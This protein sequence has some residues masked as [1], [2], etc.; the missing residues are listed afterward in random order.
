MALRA[1]CPPDRNPLRVA[2][3]PEGHAAEDYIAKDFNPSWSGEADCRI[4]ESH[5]S[6]MGSGENEQQYDLTPRPTY[7]RDLPGGRTGKRRDKFG[8]RQ[9]A[10][11]SEPLSPNCATIVKADEELIFAA[12]RT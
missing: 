11:D 1:D 7:P 6:P 10:K 12:R 3:C 8:M 9:H 4:Y 5:S 2:R